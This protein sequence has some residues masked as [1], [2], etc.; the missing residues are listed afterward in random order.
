MERG[1]AAVQG[2]HK[3]ASQVLCGESL[4]QPRVMIYMTLYRVADHLVDLGLV[5]VL[6]TSSAGLVPGGQN[7]S[8]HEDQ[9]SSTLL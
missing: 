9:A 5:T 1:A 2:R 6:V 7:Y 3:N 4:T 8:S